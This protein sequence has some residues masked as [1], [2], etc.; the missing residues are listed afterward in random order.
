[1][2]RN[3]TLDKSFEAL[4]QMQSGKSTGCEGIPVEF[5]RRFWGLLGGDLVEMLNYSF[6]EGTLSYNQRRDIPRLLF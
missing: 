1:M 3:L 5:H 2:E 4:S 6:R